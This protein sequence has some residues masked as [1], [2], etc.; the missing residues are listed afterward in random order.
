MAGDL[1]LT[2]VEVL[3]SVLVEVA[4]VHAG[5]TWPC[6]GCGERRAVATSASARIRNLVGPTLERWV[7]LCQECVA[8]YLDSRPGLPLETAVDGWD[9]AL[10]PWLAD[11]AGTTAVRRLMRSV[12]EVVRGEIDRTREPPAPS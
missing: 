11:L 2:A 4:G 12:E 5:T 10:E 7:R 6:P 1:D 3:E 9:P 8:P